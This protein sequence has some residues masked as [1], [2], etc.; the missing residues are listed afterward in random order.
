MTGWVRL[1]GLGGLVDW[2]CL[3]GGV[4]LTGWVRLVGL[5]EL[6]GWV[7]LVGWLG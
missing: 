6:V 4:G 1:V 3:V 2:I 7:C 5:G